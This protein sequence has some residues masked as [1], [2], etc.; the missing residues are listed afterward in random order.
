MGAKDDGVKFSITVESLANNLVV[1]RDRLLTLIAAYEGDSTHPGSRDAVFAYRR[2]VARIEN[3]HPREQGVLELHARDRS[4]NRPDIRVRRTRTARSSEP[5]TT[6][7][8]VVARIIPGQT[9]FQ[10]DTLVVVINIEGLFAQASNVFVNGSLSGGGA[11]NT[12]ADAQYVVK[13][14][15]VLRA[16]PPARSSPNSPAA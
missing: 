12:P 3:L 11:L 15:A 8:A 13:L 16:D 6:S 2:E 10:R 7:S 14:D 5:P 1:E 9:A 4:P